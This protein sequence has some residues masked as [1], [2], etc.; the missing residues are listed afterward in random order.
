MIFALDVGNTNI[1]IG[2]TESDGTIV[3]TARLSTDQSKTVDEYAILFHNIFAL[4]KVSLDQLEG[5]IISSVVPPVTALLKEAVR[6][7]IGKVPLVV[8]P[9]VKTGLNIL[10]DNPGQLGSDLVA[11]AVA[12]IHYYPKPAV[13]IDMGTATTLSVIDAK[14][15]YLG[16]VILPGVKISQQTLSGM[17]SQLPK[18]SIEA[19]EKVVGRNTIDCMKSGAIFGNASMLDGL[20]TRIEE[21]MGQPVTAIATGGICPAIVPYCKREIILDSDLLIKGLI[22]IYQKTLAAP[23]FKRKDSR[24]D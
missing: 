18:I 7:L 17:T 16:G 12:A 10:I 3:F 23:E 8:G 1:C 22:L 6:L 15:G 14:G 19:P 4:R 20:I 11:N 13:V 2:C 5:G 21:E 24:R 9:G